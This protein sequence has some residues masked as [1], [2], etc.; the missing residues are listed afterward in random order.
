LQVQTLRQDVRAQELPEQ[1]LRVGL[2][3]GSFLPNQLAGGIAG[4]RSQACFYLFRSSLPRQ[5]SP[6][7]Q[8]IYRPATNL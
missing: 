4:G 3:Q 5:K 8:N 6:A 2:L 1:A 7:C